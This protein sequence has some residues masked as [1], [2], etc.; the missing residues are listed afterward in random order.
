MWVNWVLPPGLTDTDGGKVRFY[1]LFL[2]GGWGPGDFIAWIT[3]NIL[4]LP[5]VI[6]TAYASQL[7]AWVVNPA[8]WLDPIQR[9]WT[10]VTSTLLSFISPIILLAAA[11]LGAVLVIAVRSRNSSQTMREAS[12]RVVASG[13]MY[14]LILG[15]LYNPAGS[16]RNVLTAWVRLLGGTVGESGDSSTTTALTSTPDTHT[17]IPASGHAPTSDSAVVT[18]FLRPLTWLLNYGSQLSPECGKAW[19]KMITPDP[20]GG[21]GGKLSCLTA[22]QV[23]ATQSVGL[24]FVMTLIA[25]IPVLIYVRFALVVAIAFVTHLTLSILRFAAAGLAAAASVWQDRPIDEFLRFMLSAVAN[26]IVASGIIGIARLGPQFT[27]AA[28]SALSDSTLV[29]FAVLTLVYYMLAAAVWGLEKRFGPIRDWL[30]NNAKSDGDQPYSGAWRW[31]FP[32][33]LNTKATAIDRMISGMRQSGSQ[34]ATQARERF[35]HMADRPHHTSTSIGTPAGRDGLAPGMIPD[36]AET[37]AALGVVNTMRAAANPDPLN[38]VETSVVQT[39]LS[40]LKPSNRAPRIQSTPS[41]SSTATP[42]SRTNGTVVG[43]AETFG[44]V[45]AVTRRSEPP[46]GPPT[47]NTNGNGVGNTTGNNSVPAAHAESSLWRQRLRQETRELM[48]VNASGDPDLLALAAVRTSRALPEAVSTL[49]DPRGNALEPPGVR[50]PLS[51][52]VARILYTELVLRALGWR[53]EIDANSVLPPAAK[54]FSSGVDESG[55]WVTQFYGR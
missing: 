25:W 24:A 35:N 17:A 55:N 26:L 48:S 32:G 38:E 28:V 42:P 36:S 41:T 23:Q 19:V 47:T 11:L 49:G 43:A 29:H 33:G 44:T 7:V 40:R 6:P 53:G 21:I 52:H 31:L 12:Q 37:K 51:A 18:D 50:A 46:W 4:Y 22:D 15:M 27:M 3:S 39:I 1:R 45:A 13:V 10:S 14:V 2:D 20:H 30:I 54:F 5:V 16:L 8:A 9:M 34:W